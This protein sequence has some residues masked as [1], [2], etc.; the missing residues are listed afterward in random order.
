MGE[1][2]VG[3]HG[4]ESAD[5]EICGDNA[6]ERANSRDQNSFR[7]ELLDEP[8][9]LCANRDTDGEFVLARGPASEKKNGNVGATDEEQGEDGA[10]KKDERAR[11]A[12]EDFFVECD[13]A[14]AHVFAKVFG[15]RVRE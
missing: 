9:T 4:G 5:T 8:G 15:I 2:I 14:N 12:A 1:G 7:E 3:N 13:D 11:E 6:K 10:K